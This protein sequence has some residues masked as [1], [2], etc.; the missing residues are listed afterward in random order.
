MEDFFFLHNLHNNASIKTIPSENGY[1]SRFTSQKNQLR[2]IH[3]I[4]LHDTLTGLI[5]EMLS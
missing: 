5:L 1:E 4:I 2:T 3:T